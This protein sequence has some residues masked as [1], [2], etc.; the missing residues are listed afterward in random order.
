MI[1]KGCLG[2][3]VLYHTE[4]MMLWG[5]DYEVE[6]L[7]SRMNEGPKHLVFPLCLHNNNHLDANDLHY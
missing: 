3:I 4:D 2:K 6:K 5:P 1:I 7:D